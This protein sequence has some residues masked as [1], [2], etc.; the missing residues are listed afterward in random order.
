MKNYIPLVLAVLLGLSAVMVVQR[1]LGDKD[2]VEEAPVTLTVVNREVPAGAELTVDMLGEKIVPASAQPALATPA[3]MKSRLV[4]QKV[5]RRIMAN[6]YILL[7][8]LE[9]NRTM[10]GVGEWAVTLNVGNDGIAAMVQPGDEV[11]ILGTFPSEKVIPSADLSAPPTRI[12]EL[13]TLVLF[14]KVKIMAMGGAGGSGELVVGLPPKEAQ[15]LVAAQERFKLTLALR[16]P[17]DETAVNRVD[18]GKVDE[19]SFGNLTKGLLPVILPNQ[20]GMFAKD[21]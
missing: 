2:K 19:T 16:R 5:V 6:D 10:V 12:T 17:G 4:G 21:E 18:I 7:T 9:P 3:T 20:P 11:A 14:P 1:M 15:L 13:A 8:D